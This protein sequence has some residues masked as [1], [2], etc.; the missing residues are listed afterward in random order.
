MTPAD[1]RLISLEDRITALPAVITA[2]ERAAE[3]EA[4]GDLTAVGRSGG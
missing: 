1:I 3:A 2:L 4:T